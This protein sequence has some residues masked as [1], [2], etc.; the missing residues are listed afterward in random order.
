MHQFWSVLVSVDSVSNVFTSFQALAS[1]TSTVHAGTL[2]G[3]L[4]P[5]MH[6][7]AD[8]MSEQAR[9]IVHVTGPSAH[10]AKVSGSAERPA[11]SQP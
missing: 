8:E 6:A 4:Q 3:L 1:A 10:L 5:S 9:S 7:S 11:V 2:K